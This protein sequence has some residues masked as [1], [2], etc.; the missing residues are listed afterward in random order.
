[1]STTPSS[2]T[3]KLTAQ[4]LNDIEQKLSRLTSLRWVFI[5]GLVTGVATAIGATIVAAVLFTWL[6]WALE[7]ADAV[8]YLDTV[9][10]RSG[11][12]RSIE[13]EL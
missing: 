7:S 11:V 2:S 4:S 1:M 5:R 12:Q 8:P 3:E 13:N 10:E 9:L 6:G